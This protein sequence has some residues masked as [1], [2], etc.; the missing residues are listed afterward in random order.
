[1]KK[2]RQEGLGCPKNVQAVSRE[3]EVLKVLLEVSK[4]IASN[5]PMERVI[6]KISSHLKRLLQT[7]DCSVMI[8]DESSRE[9]AFCE[10]SGLTRWEVDNI[11]F[12]LGEGV[13]GWVA[14]KKKPVLIEDVSLDPRFKNVEKQRRRMISMICVPLMIKRRVIGVVSLSTRDP[15][16]VFS[17]QELELTVLMSAHISLAL[18]N[19]RLYEISVL[20]GL[21]SLYN[22]RYLEQRLLKE[23]AYCQR[24]E[25]PLTVFMIDIDFF[26]RLNDSY[27][28]QAGDAVLRQVSETLQKALRE[29]DVVARYGGE[30]FAV[31]L[32]ATSKPVGA[33]IAERLRS[34]VA[35]GD[36]VHQDETI[37]ATVSVGVASFP[38]DGSTPDGLVACADK[39]LYRAKEAGRNQVQ[40]WR[41]S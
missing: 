26:K 31:L 9:L 8:L 39:A 28:H 4:L 37:P 25:K 7:D 14:K 12:K 18:E 23:V 35:H 16:H 24:Y 11:R 2:I 32:P 20:D 34:A 33:S 10:S 3:A 22:R 13:A 1:M 17:R 19:N 36:F 27:G 38:E 15:N 6:K 21:T 5:N 40:I 29:Y 41:G 30:E